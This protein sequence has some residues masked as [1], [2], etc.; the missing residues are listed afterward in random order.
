MLE[1][2]FTYEKILVSICKI[3]AKQA[4]QRSKKHLV[5]LLSTDIKTNYHLNS[6][7]NQKDINEDLEL[8]SSILPPR[9]KWKKLKKNKRYI[10]NHQKIDSIKYN[11]DSLLETIRYYTEKFPNES[12]IIKLNKFIKDIQNSICDSNFSFSTPKIIPQAKSK[13]QLKC[14]PIALFGLKDRIIIS[15]A[16]QYLSEFFDEHFYSESHA[17]RPKRFYNGKNTVTSHHHAIDSILKYKSSYKG[18]KLYVSECDISKF[19]DSVNHTI[20]KKC[21]KKLIS[22]SS[23]KIDPNAERIFY[24]YLDSYSFVHNVNIYNSEKHSEY[25][26]INNIHNGFFGWIDNELKELKYYKNINRHRIGIP[27]GGAISGLIANI[28]LHFADIDLLKTKDSKLHYVRFCDDMVIIH[29]YKMQCQKYYKTYTERL[30]KLKLVPHQPATFNFQSRDIFKKFWSEDT[31][32]KSPY[33]WSHSLTN[34]TRWIGFV[35][36]EVSYNN[37]IR[38]RK[39]SLKKEKSKQR[40]L[41]EQTLSS[42]KNG[43]RKSKDTIIESVWNRLI[44]MSV[45]RVN[46]KNYNRIENDFCWAK[47]FNRLSKN[48]HIEKQLKNLD[49]YRNKQISILKQKLS[50]TKNNN[51][52]FIPKFLFSCIPKVSIFNSEEIRNELVYLKILSSKFKLTML[53][54]EKIKEDNF[55]LQLSNKYIHIEELIIKTL[56]HCGNNERNINYYGKPFSY[57]YHL[58]EKTN[59]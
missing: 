54:Y 55:K 45:G 56:I 18:K 8:L 15:L 32:S 10:N 24:K 17:F 4:K 2:Y 26:K 33:K 34:S 29:P 5:H 44:G 49:K 12:F 14:R 3:R 16:N 43:Q 11:T 39:R 30:N 27:Q 46:M 19:Y 6:K 58:L 38:V 21:F 28:V 51:D 31:K 23:L 37:E 59:N 25:W 7:K 50:S 1:K 22:Q 41:I 57:Y 47:G 48:K 53:M 40:E 35:G 20:V 9:R 13:G 36:Y 52:V 42:L